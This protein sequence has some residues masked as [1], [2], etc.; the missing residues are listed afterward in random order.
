MPDQVMPDQVM[1]GHA[2]PEH[3]TPDHV[4]PDQVMPDQVMPDH[5]MPDQVMPDH[6]MPDQVIPDHVMPDQDTPYHVMPDQVMPD[7]VMPF[8]FVPALIPAATAPESNARPRTSTSPLTCLPPT[9][10]WTDP[11]EA[12]SEP[13]PVDTAKV[14]VAFAGVGAA[15]AAARSMRPCPCEETAASGSDRAVPVRSAF[16]WSG[17]SSGRC[18]RSSAAA[19]ETTAVACEVPLPRNSRS[20]MRAA[21][22]WVSR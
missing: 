11:R 15:E 18:E 16:T 7:H 1:P 3:V 22:Y 14:C 20:P 19:P 9:V 4:M 21:G 17:V 12:S 13:T 10:T 8:Q 2:M 6:V 5:V